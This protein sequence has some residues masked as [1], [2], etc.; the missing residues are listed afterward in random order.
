M[1][2]TEHHGDGELLPSETLG[3]LRP[4]TCSH[5]TGG[6]MMPDAH[7]PGESVCANCGRSTFT[8]SAEV[9]ADVGQGKLSCSESHIHGRGTAVA[10]RGRELGIPRGY[11][12]PAI[13][14]FG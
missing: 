10:G 8:P 14:R 7:D 12:N 9:L 13:R 1:V 2:M 4:R 5:C 3:Q 11:V 6:W